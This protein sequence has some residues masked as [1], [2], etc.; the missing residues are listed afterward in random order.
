MKN[1]KH[2]L[3]VEREF[4]RIARREFMHNIGFPIFFSIVIPVSIFVIV[5][6]YFDDSAIVQIVMAAISA[7]GMPLLLWEGRRK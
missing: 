1:L 5:R 7:V 3:K 6:T 2:E 4:R